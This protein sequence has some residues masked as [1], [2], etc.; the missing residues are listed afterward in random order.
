MFGYTRSSTS[1]ILEQL[2][3][4]SLSLYLTT[5]Q[6]MNTPVTCS[7]L[8]LQLVYNVFIHSCTKHDLKYILCIA[9]IL[10]FAFNK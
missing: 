2:H 3:W 4:V 10:K 9:C 8:M 7:F 5:I 6:F 1:N